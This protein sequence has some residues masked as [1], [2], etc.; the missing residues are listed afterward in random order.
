MRLP[1][2]VL[3]KIVGDGETSRVPLFVWRIGDAILIGQMNETYSRF[4]LDLRKHFP[5]RHLVVMN[6][7]NGSVGYLPPRELYDT[8]IYQVWQ[9][10]Y[11]AGSL[12]LL[13]DA[14]SKTVS[15]LL[16]ER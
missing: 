12:E 10:P 2:A 11:A 5:D 13:I 4:Q 14:A 15:V 8:D 3:R 16:A 9:S 6:L 7:V 1:E